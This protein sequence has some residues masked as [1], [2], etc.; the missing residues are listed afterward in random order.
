MKTAAALLLAAACSGALAHDSW[1]ERRADGSLALG[2]GQQFPK[3][4]TL[5]DPGYITQQGCDAAGCWAQ[6]T[7]FELDLAPDKIALYLDEVRPPQAVVDAWASMR[8]RGLPWHERYAKHARIVLDPAAAAVPSGM[9]MDVLLESRGREKVF[10][11]LRDG[12]PLPAFAVE[13][14]ND[15]SR[16]GIWRRTDAEG[17]LRFT[18]PFAGQWL[19]RGVDLRVVGDRFDSRFI[20]LAFEVRTAAP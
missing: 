17:R 18:P 20:S 8:T 4:E 10:Q 1:F 13:L 19:L 2:T 15:R 14:R 12:R 7:T 16:F 11:V 3:Q 9:A 5:I 6:T